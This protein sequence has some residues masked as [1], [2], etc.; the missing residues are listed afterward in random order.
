MLVWLLVV[1]A[2]WDGKVSAPWL[3][4][5]FIAVALPLIIA[6]RVSRVCGAGRTGRALRCDQPRP[7]VLRRCAD[8][9]GQMVTARDLVAAYAQ[10]QHW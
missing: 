6:I 8:H 1:L 4:A 9:T 5:A 3:A 7:G 10:P 2:V